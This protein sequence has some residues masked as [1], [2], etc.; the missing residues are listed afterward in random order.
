[1]KKLISIFEN[2]KILFEIPES[3]LGKGGEGAVYDA[4]SE[5]FK[6]SEKLVLKEYYDPSKE[7]FLKIKAMLN[8]TPE[9][10]S[11]AWPKAIVFNTEGKF[12]GYLM[13][14]LDS[15]KYKPLAV[16]SNSKDRK[17]IAKNYDVKYAFNT[18]LNISIAIESAHDV[19]H[20]IGDINESNILIAANST[21]KIVDC[22]SAQI[23]NEDNT[24]FHCLVGKPEY[25]APELSYGPLKDQERTF[26][27]DCYALGVIF[28]QLLTGGSHP[29][30]GIFKGAGDPPNTVEKI[31]KGIYPGIINTENEKMYPAQ[32]IPI[33]G[34]PSRIKFL[35]KELLETNP[36]KR[37]SIKTIINVLKDLMGNLKQCSKN[38]MHWFDARDGSCGWCKHV[39]NGQIDPWGE[40]P[41]VS[42]QI[43]LPEIDL[44]DHDNFTPSKRVPLPISNSKSTASQLAPPIQNYIPTTPKSGIQQQ[45]IP[46]KIKGKTVLHYADGTYRV[47][48][49]YS[50]LLRNNPKLAFSC[51]LEE[52]PDILK[53]WFPRERTEKPGII[54]L[55]LGLVIASQLSALWIYLPNLF[56]GNPT[57]RQI[58]I[59]LGSSAGILSASATI[60]FT[61]SAIVFLIRNNR[62]MNRKENFL[63]TITRF[64]LIS[65]VSGPGIIIYAIIMLFGLILNTIINGIRS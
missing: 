27:S 49:P 11:L 19:G 26:E 40:T 16:F 8:N 46:S 53:I 55:L 63:K 39:K 51:F 29:T 58:F 21:V 5:N 52:T 12:V 64:I 37:P 9:N 41:K 10:E 3:P 65:I 31:R 20:C 59:Y 34:I 38:K 43:P 32:R 47:R 17:K 62:R 45:T 33:V 13:E 56:R 23:K 54:A 18:C 24:I 48:P 57:L 36:N 44:K 4:I 7:R 61:I 1:M 14:K 2:E 60:F 42:K 25:T 28:F 15:N 50:I 30:D 6:P 22:D 35:I